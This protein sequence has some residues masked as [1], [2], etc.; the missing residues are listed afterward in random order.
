MDCR[1]KPGNGDWVMLRRV[2]TLVFLI[3]FSNNS[4]LRS[5]SFAISPRLSREFCLNLPSP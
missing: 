1:S 4:M 2:R 5:H 3:Q